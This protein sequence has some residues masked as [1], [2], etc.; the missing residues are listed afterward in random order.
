MQY[1]DLCAVVTGGVLRWAEPSL[2]GRAC[3]GRQTYYVYGKVVQHAVAAF[4]MQGPPRTM[5]LTPLLVHP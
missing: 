1:S 5:L 4:I 3:V 2:K